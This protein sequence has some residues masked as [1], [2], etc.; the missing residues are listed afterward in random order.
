M[1]KKIFAMLIF[2]FLLI[3]ITGYSFA[4]IKGSTEGSVAKI[5]TNGFGVILSNDIGNVTLSSMVPVQDE[6]GLQGS[7][8]NFQIENIGSYSAMYTVSLIDGTISSTMSNSSVRYKLTRTN[9]KTNEVVDFDIATLENTGI[10]DEGTIAPGVT[11]TYTMVMWIDYNANPNGQTFS[12][13]LSINGRSLSNLDTSGANYPELLNNMI[14]IYY[15]T[16]NGVW[17]KADSTNKDANYKWFNYDEQMW[18]NAITV[19]ENGVNTR[20]YY[21]N[22]AKG[23]IIEMNDVT[24]MWVWVPRYKYVVFNGNNGNVDEQMISIFFEHGKDK[25]GTIN[26]VNDILN[27]NNSSHSEVCTDTINGSIIDQKSTYTH[28]AFTFGNEELTGFWVGKFE[29]STDDTSCNE[30][31]SELNCNKTGLNIYVKPDQPSLGYQMISTIF[32]NIRGMELYHNIHGFKQDSGVVLQNTN[33]FLTGELANDSNNFDTHM[34]KNMEWG[35][36]AYLSQSKYGKKGN[37][38]YEDAYQEVYSNNYGDGVTNFKTGYSGGLPYKN[39]SSSATDTYLYNDLTIDVTGQ[40]YRGAGASTTG[41][42]YGVYDM[43]GGAEDYVMGNLANSSG[44]YNCDTGCGSGFT[45]SSKYYDLYSKTENYSN[46]LVSK[47]GDAG[48]EMVNGNTL[49]FDDEINLITTSNSWISR[50]YHAMA[51]ANGRIGLFSLDRRDGMSNRIYTSRPVLAISREM[52]W[53]KK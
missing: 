22:A 40:G 29:M 42:V 36:V 48:K 3:A 11:Y 17:K 9:Q 50:G 4:Y 12:K 33:G 28:P 27:V 6:V 5:T 46:T 39:A 51:L 24:T 47:F 41:N 30:D 13:I 19:K 31:P 16:I 1:K 15:D 8:T 18:A 20:D 25:T 45:P 49:W 10:I 38:L 2:L 34:I 23:T 26:C 7:G 32:Q 14:P 52:P 53:L 21:L 44:G 37:S 35:A 43:S